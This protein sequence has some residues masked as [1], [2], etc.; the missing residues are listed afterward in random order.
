MKIYLD[1]VGCRLNQ[2]EIES[3]AHQFRLSG[4]VIVA[5]AEGADLAVVNTCAVT[6]EA[7]SDSRGKIRQAARAG[8]AE[9]IVT[10][11]WATLEPQKAGELPKVTRSNECVQGLTGS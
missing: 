7:A 9:I 8:A 4:H 3:M 1:T 10:G 5:F 11:C 6:G 2:A